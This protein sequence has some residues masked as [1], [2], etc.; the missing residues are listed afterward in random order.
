MD[1]HVVALHLTRPPIALP[2]REAL[3]I[4]S[5]FEAARG[6]YLLRDFRPGAAH[7]GTVYV[8]GTTPVANLCKVLPEID[9]RGWN[10]RIV[11]AV[12]PQLFRAQSPGYR[13]GIVAPTDRWDAMAITNRAFK[14]MN[15]WVEGAIARDYSLS[16]D[17]DDRW[18]TGGTL[19]EVMDE[20][21]LTEPYIL[22]GIE[23]FVRERASR[24]ARMLEAIGE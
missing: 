1:A 10:L 16:A 24:R 5:H 3:R 13:A 14:L 22:D 2:D 6:A 19:E 7:D 9:R 11:C 12:S 23:R 8:Q 4:P 21:H 20:A 18:R 17:W 15:D